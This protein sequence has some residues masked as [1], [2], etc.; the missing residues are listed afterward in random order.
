MDPKLTAGLSIEAQDTPLNRRNGVYL[1]H[2]KGYICKADEQGIS[3]YIESINHT[4]YEIIVK[5]ETFAMH[6]K[7]SRIWPDNTAYTKTKHYKKRYP[8]DFTY[9]KDE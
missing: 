9:K 2:G 5:P 3:I 8:E 6:F 7:E 1:Q 4:F